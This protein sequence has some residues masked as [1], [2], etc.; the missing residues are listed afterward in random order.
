MVSLTAPEEFQRILP[1][2][3]IFLSKADTV[4]VQYSRNCLLIFPPEKPYALYTTA[5]VGGE[6]K[7]I[8]RGRNDNMLDKEKACYSKVMIPFH[9]HMTGTETC[10][11]TAPTSLITIIMDLLFPLQSNCDICSTLG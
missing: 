1:L 7:Y 11:I 9:H 4:T 2:L 6:R 5:N 3:I 8:R 10:T